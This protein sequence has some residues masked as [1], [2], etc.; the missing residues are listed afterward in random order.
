MVHGHMQRR[1]DDDCAKRIPVPDVYGQRSRGRQE[2]TEEKVDRHCQVRSGE[3]ATHGGRRRG[4]CCIE[5]ENPRG[6]PYQR[7]LQPEG[8]TEY[9]MTGSTETTFL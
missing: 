6:S 2:K 4:S 5:K 8:Q 9:E 1:E 3:V 7:N